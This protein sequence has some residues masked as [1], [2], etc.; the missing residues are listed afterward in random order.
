MD[1]VAARGRMLAGS[2]EDVTETSVLRDLLRFGWY[3][4]PGFAASC[5]C[6]TAFAA[7]GVSDRR[8]MAIVL[9]VAPAKSVAYLVRT[10]SH[11]PA[12][13]A[14]STV[15]KSQE[16]NIRL[17]RVVATCSSST[18]NSFSVQSPGKGLQKYRPEQ[19]PGIRRSWNV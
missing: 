5:S 10:T 19:Y 9:A 1:G 17:R 7:N 16:E 15:Q 18:C 4:Y 2:P 11:A 14:P 3:R 13:R 8:T 12:V 6:F